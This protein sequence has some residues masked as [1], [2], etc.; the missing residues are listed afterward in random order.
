MTNDQLILFE[1][2]A[3]LD[4]RLGCIIQHMPKEA[5]EIDMTAW[6][7]RVTNTVADFVPGLEQETW[8]SWY[9][10]RDLQTL[11]S[12]L[13]TAFILEFQKKSFE[14]VELN[15]RF[16]MVDNVGVFVNVYP[17]Q[18]DQDTKDALKEVLDSFMAPGIKVGLIYQHPVNLTPTYL[19][20]NYHYYG[21]YNFDE[22]LGH[23]HETLL[24]KPIPAFAVNAPKLFSKAMPTD[25]DIEELQ[26]SDHEE[27]F[28]GLELLLSPKLMVG[29][30]EMRA[31]SQLL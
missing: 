1:L 5:A 10:K 4:T 19:S 6:C 12:S 24:E 29:F 28:S 25:A 14:L 3:L 15:N 2:D 30:L 16:P 26:L 9:A 17:Y 11:K 8:E 13:A 18:L 31:F 21:L 20:E 7:S 23:Q 22:W 27:L